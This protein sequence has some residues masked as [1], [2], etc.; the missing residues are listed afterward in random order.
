MRCLVSQGDTLPLIQRI[1]TDSGTSFKNTIVKGLTERLGADHHLTTAYSKEQN[2]LVERQNKEVLKHLRNI[3]HEANP[4][5]ISAYI[6]DMQQAQAQIIALCEQNLREKDKK[7]MDNYPQRRTVFENG[8]Y[9]LAEHR[10]NSLRR[11]PKSKL[12]PFLRGPMLVKSHDERGIYLS[13]SASS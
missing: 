11:G 9:V 5:Y 3:I 4:I 2:G 7:H 13:V 10:H 6:R 1:C 12:S 8:A